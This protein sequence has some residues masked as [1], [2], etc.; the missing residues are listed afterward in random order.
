MKLFSFLLL[1]LFFIGCDDDSVSSDTSENTSWVFVANEGG[2]SSS[3][4][5]VSMIDSFGNVTE[6]ESLGDVVQS[7]LVYEDKLFVAVNNSQKLLVF[8]ISTS[9]LSNMQEIT[10]DGLSPREMVVNND[11]L[12]VTVWDPDYYFIQW[13]QVT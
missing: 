6:T 3:N 1:T 13:C 9:G 5:T 2:F 10:T 4:G 7:V 8:D 12:Y 11:K